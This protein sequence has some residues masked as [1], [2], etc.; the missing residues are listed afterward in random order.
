M[1]LFPMV[2]YKNMMTLSAI[3][4]LIKCDFMIL[5]VG[6][7]LQ[8]EIFELNKHYFFVYSHNISFSQFNSR[9]FK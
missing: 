7:S 1:F 3:S 2:E 4:F 5:G 8:V 6:E 9:T